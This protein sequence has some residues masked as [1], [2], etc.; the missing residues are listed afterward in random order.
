LAFAAAVV[1]ASKMATSMGFHDADPDNSLSRHF[2]AADMGIAGSMADINASLS[3]LNE[4]RLAC[5][6][7][8][9]QTRASQGSRNWQRY[10]LLLTGA[11]PAMISSYGG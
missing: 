9:V 11:S 1:A 3:T 6:E 8:C 7:G 4:S 2:S 5:E 10:N